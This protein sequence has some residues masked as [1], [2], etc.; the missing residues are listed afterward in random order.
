MLQQAV[1]QDS[2]N[3][4]QP[5]QGRHCHLWAQR[6]KLEAE[7]WK[8]DENWEEAKYLVAVRTMLLVSG[9]FDCSRTNPHNSLSICSPFCHKNHKSLKKQSYLVNYCSS[10]LETRC[11]AGGFWA[12]ILTRP[13]RVRRW[14][15][16]YP[17]RSRVVDEVC[18]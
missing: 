2:K 17:V 13:A 1:R 10:G 4:S 18:A 5:K 11:V 12:V 9:C 7:P 16:R 14:A 15:R 3:Q 6:T 8:P